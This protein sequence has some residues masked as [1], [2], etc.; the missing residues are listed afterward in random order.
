[1]DKLALLIGYWGFFMSIVLDA[2]DQRILALLQE[3]AGLSTAEI[4]ERIGDGR[5]RDL[6][7]LCCP[8]DGERERMLARPFHAG[9]KTQD[10]GLGP[11]RCRNDGGDGGPPLGQRSGLI[12]GDYLRRPDLLQSRAGRERSRGMGVW[13]T[14][15]MAVPRLRAR[16][17]TRLVNGLSGAR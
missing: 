6:S 4:A 9:G 7:L 8:H 12:E 1:M 10:V 17:A 16:R 13:W 11:T 5:E 3:D 15:H 2:Y 14:S